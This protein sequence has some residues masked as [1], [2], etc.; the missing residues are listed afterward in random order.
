[1]SE[2][3]DGGPAFP[4]V[5][6]EVSDQCTSWDMGMSLRDWFAGQVLAGVE[7]KVDHRRY[8]SGCGLT[9][10]QWIE[11]CALEDAEYCYAKAD[12]MIAAREAEQCYRRAE[13]MITERNVAK[14]GEA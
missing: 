14:G 7:S 9:L 10:K 5:P 1:M 3:N 2:I 13:A 8:A 4:N 12:A 6:T 11:Q